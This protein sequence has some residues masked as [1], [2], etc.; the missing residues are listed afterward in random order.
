M[1]VGATVEDAGFDVRPTAGGLHEVLREALRVAPGLA[2]ATFGEVRVGLRPGC[3]DGLPVLGARSG[4]DNAWV[5]TGHGAD[6][7]LLGP[8]SGRL[9][10]DLVLG[11]QP[12]VD[13]DLTAFSPARF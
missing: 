5:A 7:L 1:A 4:W 12:A 3:V 6:G 9:V 13:F 10:A 8:V 2:P 11:H